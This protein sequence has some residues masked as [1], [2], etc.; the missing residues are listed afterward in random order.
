MIMRPLGNTG[1]TVSALG[2]GGGPVGDLSVDDG[3][4]E[5]LLRGAVE[6]GINL[7]DT[8]PSYG[9]SEE[10]IG[11]FLQPVRD[12]VVLSTKGGYGVPGV[13]EWTGECIVAGVEQALR[14]LCTDRI[15]LFFLHSCPTQVLLRD[16][17][18]DA[19]RKVVR[20]GKVRVAAY[21]GDGPPLAAAIET[22]VFGC[23]QASVNVVD[24]W[25]PRHELICARERGLG[26]LGKRTMMN[27]AF[28]HRERP[29]AQDVA[30]YWERLR[31]LELDP[32]EL[33]W[34]ALALRFSVFHGG[35]DSALVGTS[36]LEHL[37]HCAQMLDAGPL[38]DPVAK[39][40]GRRYDDRALAWPGQI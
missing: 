17:L 12:R 37:Q 20:D 30:L 11:R 16:D 33:G 1:L 7:V 34:E 24:Q 13:P 28:R 5:A 2:L 18:L 6:L 10:R 21:S 14:R 38:P 15:D 31:A 19:C 3:R 36:R 35:V 29:G 4:A 25:A 27:A 39:D 32:R 9:A 26:I 8:A 22:G 40:I 23:V